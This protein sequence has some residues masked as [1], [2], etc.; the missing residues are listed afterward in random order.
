M[1]VFLLDVLIFICAV[2]VAISSGILHFLNYRL[3][4]DVTE[5]QTG[6]RK[7]LQAGI[8]RTVIVTGIATVI[9]AVSSFGERLIERKARENEKWEALAT[10]SNLLENV[11]ALREENKKQKE[12]IGQLGY[13][14]G[15]NQSIDPDTR[16]SILETTRKYTV[17]ELSAGD[18]DALV[19]GFSNRLV[20]A[21]IDIEREHLKTVE[22]QKRFIAPSYDVWDHA[23]RAFQSKLSSILEPKGI[24]VESTYAKLPDKDAL[25]NKNNCDKRRSIDVPAV[26]TI[27]SNSEWKCTCC[28][29]ITEN[30]NA[31]APAALEIICKSNGSDKRLQISAWNSTVAYAIRGTRPEIEVR[32]SYSDWKTVIDG[33]VNDFIGAIAPSC[34][35]ASRSDK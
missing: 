13:S 5:A 26:I 31:Q 11:K 17:G 28:I 24:R 16:S 20:Q 14:L 29:T 9:L 19:S 33:A 21:E 25:C 12:V 27:T 10:Q 22:I 7:R 35:K 32:R 23:I 1:N 15:K 2:A 3:E 34:A 4:H 8:V 18:L 6:R 30:M